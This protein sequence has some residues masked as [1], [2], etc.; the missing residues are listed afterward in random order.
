MREV[1]LKIF[2]T[3]P[4]GACPTPSCM[5][6]A[7]IITQSNKEIKQANNKPRRVCVCATIYSGV[8]VC[9]MCYVPVLA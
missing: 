2:P 3:P 5:L 1:P 8:L 4:L 6:S 9:A 7:S